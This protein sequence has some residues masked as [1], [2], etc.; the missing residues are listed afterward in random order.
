M[1]YGKAIT[2]CGYILG[3]FKENLDYILMQFLVT[4]NVN[5]LSIRSSSPLHLNPAPHFGSYQGWVDS[6]KQI[7]TC[8][9]FHKLR[10]SLVI[11]LTS[12]VI[13]L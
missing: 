1:R 8:N 5:Y 7:F 10:Y 2:Y 3:N 13:H 9:W 4:L 12:Y 6:I 11:D